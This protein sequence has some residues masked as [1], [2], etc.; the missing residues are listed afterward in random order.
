MVPAA[1]PPDALQVLPGIGW[2]VYW[3]TLR[4]ARIAS[5]VSM[6]Q[7][8]RTAACRCPVGRKHPRPATAGASGQPRAPAPPV[9]SHRSCGSARL[10]MRRTAHTDDRLQRAGL[11]ESEPARHVAGPRV[12]FWERLR[13]EVARCEWLCEGGSADAGHVA[14]VSAG[15]L[16]PP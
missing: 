1:P 13:H 6:A 5:Q 2:P 3:R 10:C 9:L 8:Y 12:R 15:D 11:V 4:R 14:L 7:S 16:S